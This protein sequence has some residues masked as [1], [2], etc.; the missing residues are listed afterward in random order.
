M[1]LAMLLC[2]TGWKRK[3]EKRRRRGR[4]STLVPWSGLE[5]RKTVR[6]QGKKEGDPPISRDEEREGD[7][8]TLGGIPIAG[9]AGGGGGRGGKTWSQLSL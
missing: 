4:E 3:K 2:M 5:K 6:F 9:R 7:V 1:L 8:P